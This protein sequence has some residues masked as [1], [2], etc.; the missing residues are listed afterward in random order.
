VM[1]RGYQVGRLA[2][3]RRGCRCQERRLGLDTIVGGRLAQVE[4][5]TGG[6]LGGE[7]LVVAGGA[8]QRPAE[9]GMR[10]RAEALVALHQRGESSARAGLD[11]KGELHEQLALDGR[12]AAHGDQLALGLLHYRRRWGRRSRNGRVDGLVFAESWAR[13]RLL[14][15]GQAALAVRAPEGVGGLQI[16]GPHHERLP[17]GSRLVASVALLEEAKAALHHRLIASARQLVVLVL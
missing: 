2:R 6:S 1:R 15:A 3:G 9:C 17:E 5:P 12:V 10:A 13:A 4:R 8:R 11:E 16:V 14:Q 7:M